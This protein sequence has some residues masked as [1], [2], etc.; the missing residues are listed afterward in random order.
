MSS[1]FAIPRK[2]SASS[3]AA[4]TAR[5]GTA[6]TPTSGGT[7]QEVGE[8]VAG[9][10]ADVHVLEHAVAHGALR[11]A[12]RDLEA[13]DRVDDPPQPRFAL[14]GREIVV[15]ALHHELALV[16]AVAPVRFEP[17]ARADADERRQQRLDLD[18]ER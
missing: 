14:L 11:R 16:H 4:V 15:D 10:G 8:A 18:D 12:A 6:R 2:V 3:T 7:V 5:D 1:A 13:G 9:I 17:V